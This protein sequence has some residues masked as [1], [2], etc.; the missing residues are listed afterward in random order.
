MKCKW[1]YKWPAGICFSIVVSIFYAFQ[2]CVYI[3]QYS[4]PCL[5]VCYILYKHYPSICLTDWLRIN[6]N[7]L[8]SIR[9]LFDIS[10]ALIMKLYERYRIII[11][12]IFDSFTQSVST[13]TTHNHCNTDKQ[14]HDTSFTCVQ[15]ISQTSLVNFRWLRTRS[16]K[17]RL[18]ENFTRFN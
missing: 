17:K 3:M 7:N 4:V 6:I 9:S 1:T 14:R 5:R 11:A 16:N 8:I 15:M 18:F 12:K 2:V 13:N 10:K